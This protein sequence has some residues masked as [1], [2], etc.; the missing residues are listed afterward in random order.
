MTQP[1]KLID[2]INQKITV[3]GMITDFH[4]YPDYSICCIQY[5]NEYLTFEVGLEQSLKLRKNKLIRIVAHPVLSEITTIPKT[6]F[7]TPTA[8][9]YGI[10]FV[11][12][13]IDEI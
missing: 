2:L 11:A 10:K 4:H 13:T 5:S 6:P 1:F 12:D 7:D 9:K 8:C 3:T